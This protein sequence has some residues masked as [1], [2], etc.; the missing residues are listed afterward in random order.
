MSAHQFLAINPPAWKRARCLR[1]KEAVDIQKRLRRIGALLPVSDSADAVS[2]G[3]PNDDEFIQVPLQHDRTMLFFL[4]KSGIVMFA[5]ES[6]GHYGLHLETEESRS[7]FMSID[8]PPIPIQ[9]GDRL[10][11]IY[12]SA[13]ECP[14][15]Q[16]LTVH[17]TT[18]KWWVDS[19]ARSVAEYFELEGSDVIARLDKRTYELAHWASRGESLMKLPTK[20]AS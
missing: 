2:I 11:F 6:N 10:T 16:L 9:L 7:V 4:E 5:G 1:Y 13:I 8:I 15:L 12:V 19:G 18:G 14:T 3:R 17:H 20:T